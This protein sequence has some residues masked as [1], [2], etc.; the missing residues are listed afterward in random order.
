MEWLRKHPLAAVGLGVALGYV[1]AQ[2]VKR[3]PGVS[4][5]PQV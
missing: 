5:L 1:F 3:I 4:R 2:Q